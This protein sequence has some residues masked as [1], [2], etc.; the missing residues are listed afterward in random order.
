MTDSIDREALAAA[1]ESARPRYEEFSSSGLKLDITRGK[2]CTAQLD[3]AEDLL[4]ALKP[5]DHSTE[6]EGDL[7][8]YGGAAKGV[9]ALREMFSPLVDVPA[10]QLVA[11]DNSSL[12]LMHFCVASSFFRA[13]PGGEKPWAGEEVVFLAPA[14]GYDRHF[15][16]CEELGV[17]LRTVAMTPEGPDMD[18][19]ERLVA[20]DAR[21][22]GIWCVP[23]YSNPTGITFSDEV[24]RRLAEMPTAAPDFRI[25][26]DNAYAIHHVRA[27]HDRLA[28]ILDACAK[29][30]N[31][32]RAFV[33]ASTSK[34]TFAGGGVS[35]FGSSQANVAWFLA[36]DSMRSIGPDKVNQLRHVRF[37]GDTA[38][39]EAHMEKHREILEPK[40]DAVATALDAD[41][42]PLGIASW[43]DPNGGYFVSLDVVPGTAR[44]IVQ[45]AKDAGVA[46]T[47]AGATFP[48]GDDPED[49][50]IRIAPS[51]PT[52]EELD[53]ALQVLT[54][55]VILA[56][57][58][59]LLDA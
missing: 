55:C 45:L 24:V 37:F 7:R 29:A 16:V 18:E 14:P 59:A 17:Q 46:L 31:E 57:G 12:S 13:L 6:A 25:Y 1:R 2:P 51:Y 26:W 35:F 11:R 36:R 44:R 34:V 28:S 58:E 5:G 21:I 15:S 9:L 47:P 22:K 38:G 54:T 43:S 39:V 3:L 49:R 10:D 20:E 50:N 41:L 53:T 30:G 42:T 32:D 48:G 33:F 52:T 19:V 8:N 4:V 23:K 27:Q 56:A 40:F